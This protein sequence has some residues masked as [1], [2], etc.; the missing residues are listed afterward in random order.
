M[1][2]ARIIVESLKKEGVDTVFCYTGGAVIKIF[3]ELYQHGEGLKLIHPRHEQGG[4]HAADGY[5]RSTGKTGVVIVTSG[6]GATNTIT[7]IATAY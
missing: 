3:D 7:G 4:T 5:A 6:P 2:G 1:N